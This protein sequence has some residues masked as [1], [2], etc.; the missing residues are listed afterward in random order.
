MVAQQNVLS[1]KRSSFKRN[2]DVLRQSNHG[3]RVDRQLFRV[4]HVAVVLFNARYSLKDHHHGAPFGAHV[5]GLE[6]SIQD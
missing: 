6:G 1:G 3:R 5:D 2:V 4:K